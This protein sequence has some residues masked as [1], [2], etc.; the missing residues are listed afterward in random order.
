MN[1]PTEENDYLAAHA[2]L[3]GTS[4]RRL[5]NRDLLPGHCGTKEFGRALFEAPFAV[6]SHGTEEDPVF[7][8]GNRKALELFEISWEAFTQTPSRYSAEPVNRE[9]RQRLLDQVG[10]HGFIDHYRGI[11]ISKNGRRFL[12]SNAV[13]WNLYD[14]R[15][16]YRGQAACFG[17]WEFLP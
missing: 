6:V 1:I 3:L 16:V 13:V 17:E 12:I 14:E 2:A 8:Y 10:R 15:N 4:Y 7:N 5:L 11:R 9:E